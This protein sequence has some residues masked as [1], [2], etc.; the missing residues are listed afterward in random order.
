MPRAHTEKNTVAYDAAIDALRTDIQFQCGRTM[1]SIRDCR[2]LSHEI[3]NFDP[4]HPLAVSTLRRFFGLIESPSAYSITTLDALARFARRSSFAFYLQQVHP[5]LLADRCCAWDHESPH[6]NGA[7]HPDPS[8]AMYEHLK[9]LD[10]VPFARVSGGMFQELMGLALQVYPQAQADEALWEHVLRNR[11]SRMLVAEYLPPLDHL[12]GWGLNFYQ[13]YSDSALTDEERYFGQAR[14][15][16]GA[17]YS[18]QWELAD[19]TLDGLPNRFQPQWHAAPQGAVL[20]MK[21]YRAGKRN[22]PTAALVNEIEKALNMRQAAGMHYCPDWGPLFLEGLAC[23]L[24]LHGDPSLNQLA[25]EHA[26]RM[27]QDAEIRVACA[28]LLP[29][30]RKV[31]G[32]LETG[33]KGV[34]STQSMDAGSPFQSVTNELVGQALRMGATNGKSRDAAKKKVD[35]LVAQSG[36]VLFQDGLSAA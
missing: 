9:T 35:Q 36:M 2:L 4:T 31:Q 17:L 3:S 12:A 23:W 26:I 21:L 20:G 22:Q 25:L 11:R 18:G 13:R 33:L 28:R 32:W 27:T 10:G 24:L 6:M 8:G 1:R 34:P 7:P 29:R 5:G 19:R 16:Q 14:V 30:L 15:A